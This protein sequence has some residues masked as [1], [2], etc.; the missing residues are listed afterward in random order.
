MLYKAVDFSTYGPVG[1]GPR[2]MSHILQAYTISNS[3][4]VDNTAVPSKCDCQRK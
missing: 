2:G 4:N 1:K 3:S